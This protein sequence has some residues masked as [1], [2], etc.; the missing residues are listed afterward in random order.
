MLKTSSGYQD[1]FY[2]GKDAVDFFLEKKETQKRNRRAL[3]ENRNGL[4]NTK[5]IDEVGDFFLSVEAYKDYKEYYIHKQDENGL[6]NMIDNSNVSSFIQSQF[7][8][9]AVA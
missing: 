7:K 2:D 9:I 3:I 8:K 5:V 1:F 4:G 6:I